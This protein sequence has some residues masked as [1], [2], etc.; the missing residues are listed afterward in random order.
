MTGNQKPESLLFSCLT[1]AAVVFLTGPAQ[2]V[3]YVKCEAIQNASSRL[4]TSYRTEGRALIENFV[5]NKCGPEQDT[6]PYLECR[7]EALGDP[8]LAKQV[9]RFDKIY[10]PRIQKVEADYKKAGCY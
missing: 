4:K 10:P 2:A 3:D 7:K 6:I 9:Q 8:I 5:A 1:I